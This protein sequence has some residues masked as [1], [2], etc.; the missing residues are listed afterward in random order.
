MAK[1]PNSFVAHPKPNTRKE[2]N[3]DRAVENETERKI[4][5]TIQQIIISHD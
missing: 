5:K 2:E 4:R 1:T 3:S